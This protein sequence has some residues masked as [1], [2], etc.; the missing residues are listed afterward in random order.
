MPAE[1]EVLSLS[2]K[3]FQWETSN[4]LDSLENIFHTKFF[5]VSSSGETQTKAQYIARLR[6]G[7]FVHNNIDVQQDTS[8]VENNT[9]TVV[10][11]GIFTATVSGNKM[12]LPLSYIEV[13]TREN[14][15]EPWKI[16]A[17]KA[18]TLQH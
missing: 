9:A 2:H 11:K 1:N 5:V 15:T 14:G 4:G 10:G 13:F 16:L 7:N 6:S 17:M 3:I 12:S 18:S 8:I